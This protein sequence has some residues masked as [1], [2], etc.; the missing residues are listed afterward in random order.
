MGPMS[1][2]LSRLTKAL[3]GRYTVDREIGAGGMA[4][5]YLAKDLKH[6]RNVALKV[7]KPE[8][9]AVVGAERFLA[10]IETT[11]KLQHS[12]I[13]PLFDS[14]EADS[15]LF[16]VMPYIE[17][18]T[19]GERLKREKQLPVD[20]A[21]G[22]ATA[23]ANA[24]QT[25]HDVGVVHR[26]IK[27]ANIL[28]SRGEPLVAD[29]G[30]ALAVGAAGGSRL[31]ETGLSV[32][33]PFYMSP[34]Q[35][36]G[37]QAIGA[38][39]DTYSLACVLYE[40]L[41]G[42]PPYPGSTAQAVLGKI[43]QGIPVSARAVRKS[44][45]LN[46][47]GAIRKALEKLPA[48]RFSGASDFARALA[49]PAFRYGETPGEA[50]A[51]TART[52]NRLSATLAASTMLLLGALG[53][54]MT[55]APAPAPTVRQ[56]LAPMWNGQARSIGTYT[57]LAPDGSG[58]VFARRGASA[59]DWQLW[60]K[61]TGSLEA[62]PIGGTANGRNVVY[63]PDSKRIG[64]VVD[65]E[66]KTRPI[67]DGATVTVAENLSPPTAMIGLAWM[68]D[69]TIL[70]E[71]P[72]FRVVRIPE[73]GGT[74]D[75]LI[76][77]EGFQQLSYIGALPGSSGALVTVCPTA[78][79]NGS[80]LHVLDLEQRTELLILEDV[81]RA[82]YL[83]TGHL[84]YVR[85]DGAVFAAP[86]DVSSLALTG[87]GIPLFDGVQL[88]ISSPQLAVADDG[89][90]LYQRGATSA[91]GREVVW[92]DRAGVVT[93]V[94]PDNLGP[95]DYFD[96]A[97]SP[98]NDRLAISILADGLPRL[99]VKELPDGPMTPLTPGDEAGLRPNWS[100][101]GRSIAYVDPTDGVAW[102]TRADGSA[103]REMLLTHP[104]RVTDVKRLPDGGGWL[105]R[106]GVAGTG[107]LGVFASAG[108]S[109][110][111]L[112]A[113]AFNEWGGSVSP[114]GRWIAYVSDQS[115][116]AQ[117]YVRP[118]PS[119]DGLVQLSTNGGDDVGWGNAGREIFYAEAGVLSAATYETEPTFR[120]TSRTP[121]VDFTVGGYWRPNNA[122]R[123]FDV[124][125]DDQRF[126]GLRLAT[127]SGDVATEV[128]Y[129]QNF[130]TELRARFG[131]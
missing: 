29:F 27:P 23:V 100:A 35:A 30:I 10:E 25:A 43:I 13:L 82:W 84:M 87:T 118:F 115:G 128:V 16:Y 48:D 61:A 113:S 72:E 122:W 88:T 47:D 46:V 49:D 44:I 55:R 120:V 110:T 107:D 41:V 76:A 22:I 34:E 124:A 59:Q 8:L 112:L 39:S 119:L 66:L 114:D 70:Y 91:V 106:L 56:V 7:L 131:R 57:A 32:G 99:W 69:G 26:D 71:A 94:D 67:G 14:G 60:Y 51:G 64:F 77:F 12:H 31:T 85:G 86:F 62:T 19:L 121:L 92:I 81:I 20:E 11:A 98:A 129:V 6:N 54:S 108:D 73:G 96:L 36:T 4:T 104:D 79:Q 80:E 58:M 90:L 18:E 109:V 130:F 68:D 102:I 75:T 33:T 93:R 105:A 5:V 2:S 9:A 111:P 125:Q 3:E 89:T 74:P 53:W 24:L 63:A 126:I 50:T 21:L 103:R 95:G 117:V 127:G 42:E 15:F 101:D 28:L 78:C 38:A 40:M 37:D 45:P 17:G 123:T 1:D 97:L 83:P 52:W 116:V 65:T